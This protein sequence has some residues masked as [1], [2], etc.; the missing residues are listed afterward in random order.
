MLEKNIAKESKS[1]PKRF[2][3]YTQS[4]L[5]T[6]AN[7]PDLQVPGTETSPKFTTPDTE[8][9]EVL[10]Q[11]FSSVFTVEQPNENM[12]L[13]QK[14]VFEKEIDSIDISEDMV[15]K[16][17]LKLKI[18]KSPGP[19]AIHPRVLHEIGE[20]ISK[21]LTIIFRSSLRNHELPDEWKHANVSSIHKKGSKTLPQN[22]RPVS[23]T[24]VVCKIMEGIIRDHIIE[25]MKINKMFSDKQFGFISGRST[26]L[27]L[28]NVLTIW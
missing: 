5:K 2:W 18:N 20:A 21:P 25:Q 17:L 16:K 8:K 11:Y 23:L 22:Y 26:T 13:F 19:D 6:R 10:L 7:V 24:S 12:P 14:R 3:K 9:A 1:N 4:K 15:R 28:L 27:Q